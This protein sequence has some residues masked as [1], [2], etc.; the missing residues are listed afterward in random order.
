MLP[1]P[2]ASLVTQLV[3]NRPAKWETWVRCLGQEDPLE[4]GRAMEESKAIQEGT[5]V[6][7]PGESHGQRSLLEAATTA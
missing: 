4:E 2:R 5:P 3:K 1:I 6:F 7:L